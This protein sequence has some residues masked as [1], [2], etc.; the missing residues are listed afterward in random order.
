MAHSMTRFDWKVSDQQSG[1]RLDRWLADRLGLSRRGAREV[2][3]LGYIRVDGRTVAEAAKGWILSGGD[4]VSCDYDP[5]GLIRVL[6]DD[7]LPLTILDE[8]P[9]WVAIDKAA[10]VAVHPLRS[11]Q[12]DT[13]LNAVAARYPEILGV[14]EGGLRSGVVHRLDVNTSGVQLFATTDKNY[15]RLREGFREHRVQKCYHAIVCGALESEGEVTLDLEVRRHRPARVAVVE[16]ST[17][18]SRSCPSH[19]RVLARGAS[20]S[21]VEVAPVTGFLHQIRV[22]LA[23]LGHPLVGDEVYGSAK[24]AARQMLHA[25]AL[26]FAEIDLQAP[27]PPD[28]RA[29]REALCSGSV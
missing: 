25:R 4:R 10:G 13:A 28:F 19:W 18:K 12:V 14:G 26:R 21:L 23:H 22:T 6:P 20:H 1:A 7:G 3:R 8:G 16:S 29:T 2:M 15:E 27:A 5:A 9:G 24:G 17:S 11:D